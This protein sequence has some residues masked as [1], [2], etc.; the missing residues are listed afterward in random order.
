M[1]ASAEP[2]RLSCSSRVSLLS[3]YGTCEPP[4][5]PPPFSASALITWRVHRH[6][7]R[8]SL[9]HIYK[10]ACKHWTIVVLLQ[11]TVPSWAAKG[12]VMISNNNELEPEATLMVIVLPFSCK[13]NCLESRLLTSAESVSMGHYWTA[14]TMG[15]LSCLHGL[16]LDLIHRRGCVKCAPCR[17]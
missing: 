15:S 2:P 1:S 13:C 9:S 11:C 8:W 3:R 14:P 6:M 17:G 12:A 10:T 7:N 16:C 5:G 4:P